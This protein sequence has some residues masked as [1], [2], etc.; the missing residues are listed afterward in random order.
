MRLKKN[1]LYPPPSDPNNKS[2]PAYHSLKNEFINYDYMTLIANT[3]YFQGIC[4][5]FKMLNF[6]FQITCLN[7]LTDATNLHASK[8]YTRF[9]NRITLNLH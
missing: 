4:R 5:Y 7:K 6:A 8:L 1:H 2:K 9:P 3:G